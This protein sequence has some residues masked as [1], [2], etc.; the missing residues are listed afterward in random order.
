MEGPA[1]AGVEVQKYSIVKLE[2]DNP[3]PMLD[4]RT[5]TSLERSAS[6]T[7]PRCPT[8]LPAMV[9][10]PDIICDVGERY[11]SRSSASISVERSDGRMSGCAR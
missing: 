11:E 6:V 4:V 1:S 7:C 3:R 10:L 9:T 8:S 2:T 5:G